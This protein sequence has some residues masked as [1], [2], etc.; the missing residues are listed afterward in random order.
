MCP[1]QLPAR[2]RC[3]H[4]TGIFLFHPK[5]P[6]HP[7]ARFPAVVLFS[8]IYQGPPPPPAPRYFP[9][10]RLLFNQKGVRRRLLTHFATA[11]TGPVARFARQIAG[12][13]YI[14]AAPSS[15]HEFTGPE[16]LAYDGPGTDEGNAYKIKKTVAAYDEDAQLSV[17]TLLE[18]PTCNGKIGA[19][20]MCLGMVTVRPVSEKSSVIDGL[21]GG[22]LAFR[23]AF[24]K[25]VAAAVCYF[26]TDIHS[27][28][29]G[30]GKRDDSLGRAG[31][32]RGEIIMIHGKSDGHVPPSGRDLI[33]QT[34]HD[35]G[36]SFSFYEIAGAQRKELDRG[37]DSPEADLCKDAFIRD[38]LSKGRYD[39]HISK[40][41][42]EMLLELFSRTLRSDLGPRAGSEQ[43]V[44]NS[45]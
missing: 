32:I 14:V 24:D 6:N 44:E 18:L 19:S 9:H 13:G 37:D 11:V 5:I 27:H 8:E 2:G 10:Q 23:C 31:D 33:R 39:P 15:Y 40:I 7:T 38:E 25:R 45:C 4:I 17:S 22:H 34:L 1:Q 35:K 21:I 16:P 29:L 3:A 36:V 28:S 12:H 30:E 43:E 41:C 26:A 42:F 20:G